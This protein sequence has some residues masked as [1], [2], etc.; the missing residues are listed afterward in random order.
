MKTLSISIFI[1]LIAGLRNLMVKYT[2]CAKNN[3]AI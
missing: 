2:A 1:T 3:Y